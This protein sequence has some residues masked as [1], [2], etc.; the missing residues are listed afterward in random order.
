VYPI[1]MARASDIDPHRA[2]YFVVLLGIVS[3][4]ADL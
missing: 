2:T 1:I 4:F 3:L